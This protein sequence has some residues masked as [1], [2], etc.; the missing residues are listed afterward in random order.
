MAVLTRLPDD[1]SVGAKAS[2]LVPDRDRSGSEGMVAEGAVA[3]QVFDQARSEAFAG[4]MVDVLNGAG[5]AL[6]ISIGHQTG[7]FDAMAGLPPS[8]SQQIATAAGLNERYVREWLGAMASGRVVEYDPATAAYALPAEH[9]AWLTRAAGADNVAISAQYVPLLAQVEAPLVE[10][11]RHGGGVPYA[12]FAR[13]QELMAEDSANVF[14]A[15]LIDQMLPLV[16]GLPERLATGIDVADIGCGSGYAITL[17]A[18]AYPNSRF[19]GYDFSE[20]GVA[21]GRARAA[22]LGLT[23]AEFEARDAADLGAVSRFDLITA[24]DAIHDQAR[25]AAVLAGIRAALRPD[26]VFLMGDFAAS[27]HL[28]ENLDQPLAPFYYTVSCMHCLTVSL[29]LD[30]AGLGAM[31]GEQTARA[32]LAEAGFGRVEVARLAGDSSHLYYLTTVG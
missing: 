28:H 3:E 8:T 19:L 5:L 14:D 27:S 26:G 30:G 16:P 25:P 4:R 29:A 9:A 20:E 11:F 18:G 2:T 31:W 13:F 23:N 22:A 32:M 10:C 15:S 12:A 6:M 7:L 1:G 17:M 21:A 24:F